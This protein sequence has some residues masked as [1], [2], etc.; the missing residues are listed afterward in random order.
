MSIPFQEISTTKLKKRLL[1]LFLGILFY[2]IVLLITSFRIHIFITA[3]TTLSLIITFLLLVI[4]DAKVQNNDE[5][6]LAAKRVLIEVALLI[7]TTILFKHFI[8][9][10]APEFCWA[11]L[12]L[13]VCFK[14]IPNI[15]IHRK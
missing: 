14:T 10:F 5:R 4:A 3:I 12:M 15:L 7:V 1:T 8:L 2:S 6:Y 11:G 9:D 13:V